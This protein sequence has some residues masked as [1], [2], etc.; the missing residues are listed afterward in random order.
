[1]TATEYQGRWRSGKRLR[2]ILTRWR[3]LSRGE[4]TLTTLL[5]ATDA[6]RLDRGFV[7]ERLAEALDVPVERIAE[8]INDAGDE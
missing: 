7:R 8:T 6:A 2:E 4:K 3:K 1:M 5:L